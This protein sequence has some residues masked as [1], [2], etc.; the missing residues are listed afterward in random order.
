M[1]EQMVFKFKQLVEAC[2]ETKNYTKLAATTLLLLRNT[3]ISHARSLQIPI[4]SD[5]YIHEMMLQVNRVLS[6]KSSVS[7]Y[8]E[9]MIA[10]IKLIESLMKK[11]KGKIPLRFIKD[12]IALYFDLQQV[13]IPSGKLM[14]DPSSSLT[15]KGFFSRFNKSEHE[16]PI[17]QLITHELSS[18]EQ[19]LRSRADKGKD[20]VAIMELQR[21]SRL[22]ASLTDNKSKRIQV[23]GPISKDQRY[24]LFLAQSKTYPLFGIFFLLVTL[25]LL[26]L[27]QTTLN[28]ALL[29][30][31]GTFF[32]MFGGGA[33]LSFYL[34]SLA[35]SKVVS[36]L[37]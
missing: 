20:E 30:P 7:P 15:S 9:S 24:L 10:K 21:I 33:A 14:V 35:K 18:R 31:L 8:K 16:S 37:W 17:L 32:L 36:S 25:S 12:A 11:G 5:A 2:L 26:V 3:V 13:S 19:L 29:A 23:N 4:R 34:Y 22:K 6:L 28:L 1:K 27:V